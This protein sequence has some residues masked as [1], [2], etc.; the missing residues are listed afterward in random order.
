[1]VTQVSRYQLPSNQLEH[2]GPFIPVVI[3]NTSG[4]ALLGTGARYYV[5]D[6]LVAQELNL[7]QVGEH[8]ITGASGGEFPLFH[9][10][11]SALRPLGNVENDVAYRAGQ[12]VL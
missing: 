9:G 6:I 5:I 7:P 12:H 8:K 10:D 11:I 2:S 4:A 3:E 1:M